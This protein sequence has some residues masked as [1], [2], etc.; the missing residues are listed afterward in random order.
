MRNFL[1]NDAASN[2]KAKNQL[3]YDSLA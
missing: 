3:N 2:K 1:T